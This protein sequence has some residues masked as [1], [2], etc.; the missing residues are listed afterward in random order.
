MNLT[1]WV[2]DSEERCVNC[3]TLNPAHTYDGD[4]I[5]NNCLQQLLVMES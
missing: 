1:T 2:D 3:G 4:S 5:C